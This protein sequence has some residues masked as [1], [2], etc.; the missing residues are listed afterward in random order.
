MVE[1]VLIGPGC[2]KYIKKIIDQYHARKILLVTGNKSYTHSGIED[3]LA[4]YL[5]E[6]N[7]IR[8]FDFTPN[9][10]LE[11][12][13]KGIELIRQIKPDI[14]I[15]I[16]GGSVIDMGKLIAILAA[17]SENDLIKIV[18]DPH[19][20]KKKGVPL[21]A[22]PTTS[23][24]GSEATHFA[25]VYIDKVKYS[26][27]HNFIL[28][29]HAIIDPLLTQRVPAYIRAS[30]AMDALA[31]AVE[32]YWATGSTQKSKAYAS[33]AIKLILPV[34]SKSVYC[35][36]I[37]IMEMLSKAAHLSGKAINITKTTAAHAISYPLTT[38]FQVPHGHAVALLLGKFF[39]IHADPD[40]TELI[41][42]RGMEYFNQV[43]VDLFALFGCNNARDCC[44]Q[45]YDRMAQIGLEIDLQA[46][47]IKN[48][49]DIWVVEQNVNM[50]R[51]NNNPVKVSKQTLHTMLVSG[52]SCY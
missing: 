18:L 17:Q 47:G 31:Q 4:P 38:Y 42:N 13:Q 29:D 25:V 6:S 2:L 32:S 21:I 44:R 14:I 8:F 3:A 51:L 39:V 50:E 24:T 48:T 10:Q 15:A 28:P 49:D 45:W 1:N 11:H 19:I 36:D 26:L 40:P 43:M 9:P 41:D 30:C 34:I 7:T 12:T 16:G 5:T 46:I 23:G 52:D 27:A 22:I 37:E 20:I 35:D 33:Q